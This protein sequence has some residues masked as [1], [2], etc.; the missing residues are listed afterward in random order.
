M[1]RDARLKAM[2]WSTAT[3]WSFNKMHTS[4]E[5]PRSLRC[6]RLPTPAAAAS[7]P[8]HPTP[9][10]T[11]WS[12]PA[13]S[14]ARPPLHVFVWIFAATLLATVP[15]I[16]R[17]FVLAAAR[18][19]VVCARPLLLQPGIHVVPNSHRLAPGSQN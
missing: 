12:V 13:R 18:L 4:P 2:R 3:H 15:Y 11:S 6:P 16:P 9:R 19:L 8:A 1:R 14:V 17:L 7:A 10:V 5:T